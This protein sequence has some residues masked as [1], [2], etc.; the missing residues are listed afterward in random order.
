MKVQLIVAGYALG[1]AFST[2]TT[3]WMAHHERAFTREWKEASLQV[4]R[5]ALLSLLWPA[6]YPM[7]MG[8]LLADALVNQ[9]PVMTDFKKKH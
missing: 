5:I 4:Q 1:W 2:S 8:P 9:C 3:I 6:T 7:L